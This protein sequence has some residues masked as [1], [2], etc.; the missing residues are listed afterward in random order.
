LELTAAAR[1]DHYQNVGHKIS[2]KLAARYQPVR[3][4][5]FR[6]SW[7]RGF[8]A[9]SLTEL[10]Q[11]QTTGVTAPGLNDPARCDTTGSP[12]DCVTQFP[13]TLGG[14]PT[15]KP[16]TSVNRTLGVVFEP[17]QNFSAA[18]DY[19]DVRLENTIIFG[20]TPAFLL[21]H[22][23][24]F[25]GFIQRAAPDA[26]CPGCPG[27][28]VNIN[29]TN[30]NLGSTY[31]SGIDLDLKYRLPAAARGVFTFGFNGTYIN[32]YEVQ[33]PDG[34]FTSV[35]GQVTFITNGNG[36]A[37]PRWRHYAYVDWRLN[38]WTFTLVQQYQ[39]GY[40]DVPGTFDDPADIAHKHVSDYMLFHLY[41]SY[42][43]KNNLRLT[44]GIRNLFD[45]KPP[46][47]NAGGQNY[48]QSGYDPGYA[49]PRMRTF[50][51]SATYKFM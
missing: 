7:S 39:R 47:T 25:P 31:V 22:E 48:F 35:N 4:V 42:Q 13:I 38:P 5:L 3:Q 21:D 46:Y 40:A 43:I 19:W 24:Q 16:E 33:N 41:T 10:Y 30:L 26:T 44:F 28:I 32:K 45:T 20:I 8:R 51:L 15:L 1:Y 11:P 36:G 49:D 14:E 9:P 2:P 50:L 37:V 29:Q 17:V 18:V 23:A 27:Q 12:R 6:T 34:T